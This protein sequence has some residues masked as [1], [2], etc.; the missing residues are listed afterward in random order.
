MTSYYILSLAL[1]KFDK[2]TQAKAAPSYDRSRIRKQIEWLCCWVC[3]Y[4]AHIQKSS[5]V[6]ELGQESRMQKGFQCILAVSYTDARFRYNTLPA[7]ER[8]IINQY[9]YSSLFQ[10]GLL[11]SIVP[12]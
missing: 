7:Y 6:N 3:N 5:K 2:N 9:Y 4:R 11:W 12:R 10:K 8:N 1:K